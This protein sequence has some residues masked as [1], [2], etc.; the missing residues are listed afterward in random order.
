MRRQEKERRGEHMR[1]AFSNFECI[2]LIRFQN[3]NNKKKIENKCK[4][5]GRAKGYLFTADHVNIWI[6]KTC[7]FLGVHQKS[8][9]NSGVV[10]AAIHHGNMEWLST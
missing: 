4:K 5:K 10:R 3:N 8:V 7:V 9:S 6:G 1:L 2:M